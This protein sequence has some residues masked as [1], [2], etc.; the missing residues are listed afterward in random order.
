[1]IVRVRRMPTDNALGRLRVKRKPSRELACVTIFVAHE[2][3][4]PDARGHPHVHQSL[5][6]LIQ[7]KHDMT[8]NPKGIFI[9][10]YGHGRRLRRR[11]R[12]VVKVF[13]ATLTF[14]LCLVHRCACLLD[15]VRRRIGTKNTWDRGTRGGYASLA[16]VTPRAEAEHLY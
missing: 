7:C 15:T 5:E 12:G 16:V 14:F 2:C 6:T 11:V 13:N 10:R 3:K 1:M 8:G 4:N 9:A